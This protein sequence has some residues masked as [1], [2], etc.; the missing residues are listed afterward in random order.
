VP[1]RAADLWSQEAIGG[2]GSDMEAVVKHQGAVTYFALQ[3]KGGTGR[4]SC[5][6]TA[7][8]LPIEGDK[9]GTFNDC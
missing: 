8:G 4:G 1:N 2:G 7:R 9:G 5:C 3:G 6:S